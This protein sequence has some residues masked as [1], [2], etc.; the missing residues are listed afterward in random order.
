[1]GPVTQYLIQ[2]IL[3]KKVRKHGLVVWYDA[4][5]A[6]RRV[7]D[8]LSI[9]RTSVVRYRGSY[10]QVRFAADEQ[11]KRL[12]RNSIAAETGVIIYIDAPPVDKRMDVLLGLEKAGT[13]FDWPLATIARE[14]LNEKVAR[15]TLDSWL[16]NEAL[17]I[18]DLDRMA[19]DEFGAGATT[20]AL[21]FGTTAAGDIAARYLTEPALA[22]EIDKRGAFEEL[23]TTF[24]SALGLP[25]EGVSSDETLRKRLGRHVLMTEFLSEI[26]PATTVPELA[27]VSVAQKAFQIEVCRKVARDLRDRWSSRDEYVALARTVENECALRS[28]K[29]D[30]GMLGKID[31]FPFEEEVLL[32]SLEQLAARGDIEAAIARVEDRR[33]SFWTIVDPVRAVQWRM[34]ETALALCIEAD[35][36]LRELKGS[37]ATPAALA[38][39]YAHGE[40]GRGHW[41]RMDSVERRLEWLVASAEVEFELAGLLRLARSKYAATAETLAEGFLKAIRRAGFSFGAVPLQSDTFNR[42]LRSLL[43]KGPVA[44]F[45]VSG[46]RYEMAIELVESLSFAQG[47]ELGPVIAAC[48]TIPLIG[49]SALLPGAEGGIALRE[50]S[51][52]LGAEVDGNVFTDAADRLRFLKKRLG[53]DAV[54]DLTLADLLTRQKDVVRKRVH[55]RKL[56]V[57]RAPEADSVAAETRALH[58]RKLM[59]DLLADVRKGIRRIADLGISQVVVASSNGHLLTWGLGEPVVEPPDGRTLDLSERSWVG[60][61]GGDRPDYTRFKASDL[62]LGGELDLVFPNKLALF[63]TSGESMPYV[64]G[65][66]SPQEVIVPVAVI[67]VGV[68]APVESDDQFELIFGRDA[69]TNRLFTVTVRYHKGSLLSTEARR[70]RI[71]ARSKKEEIG[72]AATAVNGFDQ[73]T[74]EVLLVAGQENHVTLMLT[75]DLRK[76]SLVVAIVD[77]ETE[78][79]LKQTAEVPFDF[80]I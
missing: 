45:M 26:A 55:G 71:V 48:P 7:A 27:K 61:G 43:E 63:K 40:H 51:G 65:G 70:V 2:E 60:K 54:A 73:V 23:R 30:P 14:A 31:T 21:I 38:R 75:S 18:E 47:S 78:V 33:A 10:Y 20:L 5:G 66:L 68:G 9:E 6:F 59:G 52:K 50:K 58:A 25:A 79:A 3:T 72:R 56:V 67:A 53:E 29:L 76:G 17:T 4:A 35:R 49:L 69:V 16:S 46:M 36:V 77:P 15:A 19:S 1:M 24:S 13:R 57:I 32:H 22:L 12:D 37:T 62:G 64:F 28:L 44:Y 74:G 11:F 39:A 80:S 41:Y 8:A 34:A 42:V